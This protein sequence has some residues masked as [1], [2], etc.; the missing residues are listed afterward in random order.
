[1]NIDPRKARTA[2]AIVLA[3]LLAACGSSISGTYGAQKDGAQFV[4]KSGGKVELNILGMIQEAS[5]VVEDKKVKIATAQ[6][7]QVMNID[8]QGCLDGGFMLGKL[9]RQ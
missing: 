4:F 6:G 3:A 1:M 8:A 5:Y 9:C 7:V 2:A